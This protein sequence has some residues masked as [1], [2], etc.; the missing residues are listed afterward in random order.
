MATIVVEDYSVVAMMWR[1]S[2]VAVMMAEDYD[3]AYVAE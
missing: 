1:D 2:G 3:V